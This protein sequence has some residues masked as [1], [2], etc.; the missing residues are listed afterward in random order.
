M[1]QSAK[2]T[3]VRRQVLVR[4]PVSDVRT[5]KALAAARNQTQ[6]ELIQ[7]LLQP[8]IDAHRRQQSDGESMSRV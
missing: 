4:L 5:L 7:S 8:A 1:V 2:S 6:Q 3:V